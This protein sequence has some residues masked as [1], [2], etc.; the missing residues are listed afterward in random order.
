ML[1]VAYKCLISPTSTHTRTQIFSPLCQMII[2][3]KFWCHRPGNLAEGPRFLGVPAW[4]L[5]RLR[6]ATGIAWVVACPTASVVP[7]LLLQLL[8]SLSPSLVFAYVS[9]QPYRQDLSSLS[10]SGGVGVGAERKCFES[11]SIVGCAKTRLIVGCT[12]P[13]PGA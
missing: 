6:I 12:A 11:F 4:P 9:R 2:P 8:L 7:L 10:Y 3:V 13:Y 1:D 5:F